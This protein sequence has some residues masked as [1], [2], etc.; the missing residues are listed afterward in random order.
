MQ[1]RTIVVTGLILVVI[2]GWLWVAPPRAW[3]NLIK[4]VEPTAAVGEQLIVRYDCRSCHRIGG[5]GALKA[6]S[7]VGVTRRAEDPQLTQLRAWLANPDA[8][9]S[10]TAMPNFHLSDSEI[11]ALIAYLQQVDG[12]QPN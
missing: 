2:G 11:A 8:V 12:A 3:S 4:Q 6:P 9:K 7:L 5:E 1:R 10:D